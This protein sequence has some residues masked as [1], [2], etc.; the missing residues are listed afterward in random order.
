MFYFIYAFSRSTFAEMLENGGVLLFAPILAKIFP[1]WSGYT[2]I[3]KSIDE[4]AEF[5]KTPIEEHKKTLDENY[6]R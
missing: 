6:D 1:I 2:K 4:F 5:F 3:R